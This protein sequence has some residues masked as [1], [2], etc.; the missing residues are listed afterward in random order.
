MEEIT[1]IH[2]QG[3]RALRSLEVI[4]GEK[5]VTKTRPDLERSVSKDIFGKDALATWYTWEDELPRVL[6]INSPAVQSYILAQAEHVIDIGADALFIDEHQTSS[7]LVS[8]DRH[9]AGFGPDDIAAFNRH[10][11]SQG[12]TSLAQYLSRKSYGGS[13]GRDKKLGSLFKLHNPQEFSIAAF[14]RAKISSTA[15]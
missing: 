13:F 2:A 1:K 10:L 15:I 3:G 14:L 12:Y 8:T 6:S 4:I 9:A 11:A 5:N 7:M